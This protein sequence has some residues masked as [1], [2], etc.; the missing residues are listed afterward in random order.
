M[1]TKAIIEKLQ[2][3]K[4]F[5]G[6]YDTENGNDSFMYGIL[7]VLEAVAKLQSEEYAN[8]IQAKFLKNMSDSEERVS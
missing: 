4:L 6:I 2:E 7:T 8:E 3:N 5:T 1:E